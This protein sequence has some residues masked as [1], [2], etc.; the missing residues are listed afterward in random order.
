MMPEGKA[1]KGEEQNEKNEGRENTSKAGLHM[2]DR[3]GSGSALCGPSNSRQAQ[4]SRDQ[5]PA[6]RKNGLIREKRGRRRRAEQERT[7]AVV[8][9]VNDRFGLGL[10]K[11]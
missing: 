4:E 11:G 7:Q 1:R 9:I 10:V 8:E 5:L 2:V 6:V 3:E